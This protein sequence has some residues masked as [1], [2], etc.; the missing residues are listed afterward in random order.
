MNLTCI[1]HPR[2]AG[3]AAPILSCKACCVIFLASLRVHHS[4]S[5]LPS[6]SH[7]QNGTKSTETTLVAGVSNGV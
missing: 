3:V 2:Y 1:R 5:P 6:V 7:S 4:R